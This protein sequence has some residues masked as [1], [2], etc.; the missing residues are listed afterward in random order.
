MLSD[1]V[2][3]IAIDEVTGT[4]YVGSDAGLTSFLTPSIK[5]LDTFSE[6]FFFP[7]P[8][9]LGSGNNLLT[10]DGLIKDTEIKILTIDGKLVNS[11]LSP[12]GRVA[13]WDGKDQQGRL[14]NSG[15]YLIV[16]HDQEGNSVLTGKVAVLRQ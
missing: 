4:V 14:V 15:V 8:F 16:A 1:I 12:G 11:F 5:P 3:S 10:I 6:L 7:N 9:V 13:Y 2:R